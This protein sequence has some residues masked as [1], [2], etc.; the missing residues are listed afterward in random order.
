MSAEGAKRG[1]LI[2]SQFP[3]TA[4]WQGWEAGTCW[5][6]GIELGSVQGERLVEEQE[7][8]ANLWVLGMKRGVRAV[9]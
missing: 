6:E 7:S 4:M 9:P 1:E 3:S 2:T 5:F 8:P